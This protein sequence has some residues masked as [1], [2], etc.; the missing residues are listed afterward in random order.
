MRIAKYF[1]CVVTKEVTMDIQLKKGLLEICVLASLERE[2]SYGYK[3]IDDVAKYI[4]ITESTLYP[5]LKRLEQN[6]CLT[7]RSQEY[8]GR[9]RKYYQITEAGRASLMQYVKDLAQV[10]KIY[11]YIV[12][13]RGVGK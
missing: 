13:N 2:E 9:L 6:G 12:K 10:N 1:Q 5:I 4:D 7:T 11:E 3:I 8:N